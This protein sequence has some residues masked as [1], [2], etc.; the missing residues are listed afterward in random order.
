MKKEQTKEQA[1][2]LS[3]EHRDAL[4]LNK[5][6]EDLCNSIERND[7]SAA[8]EIIKRNP[9]LKSHKDSYGNSALHMTK[10]SPEM[11]SMLISNGV[12]VNS[13]DSYSRTPL[14]RAARSGYSIDFIEVLLKA[15]A[16][17]DIRCIDGWA[18]LHRA[19]RIGRLDIIRILLKH[20]ADIG[21]FLATRDWDFTPL[22]VALWY[23]KCASESDHSSRLAYDEI[24]EFLKLQGVKKGGMPFVE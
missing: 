19:I 10:G 22:D 20:R 8:Q 21:Q 15:G 18:P 11:A 4:E 17:P 16:S 13:K 7:V 23:Q 14:Y 12:N 3:A 2:F 1:E 24:V 5:S 9:A 6:F